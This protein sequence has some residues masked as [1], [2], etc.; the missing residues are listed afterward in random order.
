MRFLLV[1]GIMCLSV[2]CSNA[3]PF[4]AYVNGGLNETTNLFHHQM[5]ALLFNSLLFNEKGWLLDASGPGSIVV[6][7]EERG[8]FQR[9][10]E[11]RV[12]LRKTTLQQPTHPASR[13]E[14]DALFAAFNKSGAK[15]V[16][17]VYGGH[18]TEEGVLLWRGEKLSAGELLAKEK[19]LEEDV[20][21]RSIHNHDFGER[22]VVSHLGKIPKRWEEF[23]AYLK[24]N[25]R[26]RSCAIGLNWHE[27]SGNQWDSQ[28]VWENGGWSRV[29]KQKE[30]SLESIQQAVRNDVALR[31][32]T[33]LTSD[34]LVEDVLTLACRTGGE[35]PASLCQEIQSQA[36][37][38]KLQVEE[39][40]Q[41]VLFYQQK[42]ARNRLISEYV[43][44]R[45]VRLWDNFLL[46]SRKCELLK[47]ELTYTKPEN[48]AVVL[49][50]IEKLRRGSLLKVAQLTKNLGDPFYSEKER[51]AFS[52]FLEQRMKDPKVRIHYPQLLDFIQGGTFA[53]AQPKIVDLIKS[54]RQ[55]YKNYVASL[56]D[57]KLAWLE[58]FTLKNPANAE[59]R[60]Y[61]ESLKSCEQQPI[62]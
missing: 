16:V 8:V 62:N 27:E 47:A 56:N 29:L 36:A 44:M 52:T 25:F 61:Y 2:H 13:L 37:L 28:F 58:K 39:E 12:I 1:L 18:A 6:E 4:F 34:F 60:K 51:T 10:D 40:K 22:S 30:L 55:S 41:L 11:G 50:Q 3:T 26:L 48:R 33:A 35:A 59:I 53:Q 42:R 24:E 21:V 57:K 23:S 31:Q 5:Q 19:S 38:N 17:I 20:L 46:D 43:T 32:L 49:G 7:E 14:I 9:N 54:S 45:E 15:K